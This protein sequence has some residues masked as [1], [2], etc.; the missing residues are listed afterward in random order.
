MGKSS[1]NDKMMVVG[2]YKHQ[3]NTTTKHT[4][5]HNNME[6]TETPQRTNWRFRV[7]AHL[8]PKLESQDLT[9]F[10][11]KFKRVATS[12]SDDEQPSYIYVQFSTQNC[13]RTI[14]MQRLVACLI[15]A[16]S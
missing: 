8:W 15:E 14:A 6:N 11:S 13:G 4:I 12:L 2:N 5:K 10:E 7:P 3:N 16:L 9:I 1:Q